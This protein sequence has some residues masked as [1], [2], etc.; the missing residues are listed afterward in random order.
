MVADQTFSRTDADSI[1][2]VVAAMPLPPGTAANTQLLHQAIPET[3][4]EGIWAVG[5]DGVTLCSRTRRWPSSW[6]PIHCHC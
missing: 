2:D 6:V 3:A 5:L 4:Q 1:V